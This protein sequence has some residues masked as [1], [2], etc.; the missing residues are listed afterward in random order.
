[1]AQWYVPL[2][3]NGHEEGPVSAR[4]QNVVVGRVQGEE[5]ASSVFANRVHFE[6]V[7]AEIP[8]ILIAVKETIADTLT[9]LLAPLIFCVKF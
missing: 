6:L 7:S 8:C 1:M 4:E 3:P 2:L 5:G 9:N